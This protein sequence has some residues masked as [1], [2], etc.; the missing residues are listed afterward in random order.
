MVGGNWTYKTKISK[1][2]F[3]GIVV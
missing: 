3:M 2:I 1:Q